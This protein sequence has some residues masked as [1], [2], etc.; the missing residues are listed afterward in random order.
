MLEGILLCIIAVAVLIIIILAALLATRDKEI[1]KLLRNG[2]TSKQ[3]VE[4]K[5]TQPPPTARPS[6]PVPKQ[7]G[8]S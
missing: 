5:S 7:P 8:L 2:Q 1:G 4:Q 6:T 3:A